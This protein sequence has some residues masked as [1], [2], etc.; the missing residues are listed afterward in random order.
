[1]KR[2]GVTFKEVYRRC[3]EGTMKELGK[4]PPLPNIVLNM[5]IRHLPNPLEAQKG[6][7]PIIWKGDLSSPVGKAMMEVNEN[8][9]VGYMVTKI[10]VDPQA[11]EV[12]PGRP[13]PRKHP[14]RAGPLVVRRP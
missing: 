12:A 1:M 4:K 14:R 8:G 3:Q 5:V 6:R 11:G 13:F 9:P 2:G 10:I 7:I